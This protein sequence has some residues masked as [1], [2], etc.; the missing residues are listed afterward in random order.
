MQTTNNGRKSKCKCRG[1]RSLCYLNQLGPQAPL[2][3]SPKKRIPI[4]QLWK[5]SA[6][7]PLGFDLQ[8]YVTALPKE[9]FA[10]EPGQ[11]VSDWTQSLQLLS[12]AYL[13]APYM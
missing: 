2:R 12:P 1:Q 7:L 5:I 13:S 3:G 4:I 6:A 11:P 8:N 9:H 10:L